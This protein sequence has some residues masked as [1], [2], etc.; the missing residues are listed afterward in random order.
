MTNLLGMRC[1]GSA[2]CSLRGA[3]GVTTAAIAQ[4]THRIA[5][6]SCF[7]LQLEFSSPSDQG[8]AP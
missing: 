7:S 3:F 2:G 6:T 5:R 8:E 1:R 4:P